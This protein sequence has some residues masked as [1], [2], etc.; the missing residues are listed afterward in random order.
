MADGVEHYRG[1]PVAAAP[2][3]VGRLL[4]ERPIDSR[5][6]CLLIGSEIGQQAVML[7]DVIREY[8]DENPDPEVGEIL[9]GIWIAAVTRHRQRLAKLVP[10]AVRCGAGPDG[11]LVTAWDKTDGSLRAL[12]NTPGPD[13]AARALGDTLSFVQTLQGAANTAGIDPPLLRNLRR[14]AGGRTPEPA[15]P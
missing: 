1:V 12:I 8:R 7:L 3:S 2:A 4:G 5:V 11:P 9:D 14:F 15:P 10:E 13:M 6:S